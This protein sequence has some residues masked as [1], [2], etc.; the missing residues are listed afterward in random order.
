MLL[1]LV[2]HAA[3]V[4]QLFSRMAFIKTK[5]RNRM[6]TTTLKTLGQ[7]QTKIKKDRQNLSKGKKRAREDDVAASLDLRLLDSN[8]ELQDDYCA[9]LLKSPEE[10]NENVESIDSINL[11]FDWK[12][13]ERMCSIQQAQ[14]VSSCTP[15][16]NN[17]DWTIE[18]I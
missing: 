3:G 12:E 9:E 13:Y 11:F 14:R 6:S 10:D 15:E 7:I 2:P 5:A 1:S 8:S 18:D 16:T 17:V 4:E